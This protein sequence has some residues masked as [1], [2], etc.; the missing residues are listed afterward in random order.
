MKRFDP[1][2]T[3]ILFL[4]LLLQIREI[5]SFL[6]HFSSLRSLALDVAIDVRSCYL[7]SFVSSCSG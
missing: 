4:V 2:M 5:N 7:R 1:Q 3:H 6:T